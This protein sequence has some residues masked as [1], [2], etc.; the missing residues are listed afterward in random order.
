MV[1]TGLTDG[2]TATSLP[3]TAGGAGVEEALFAIAFGSNFPV[4][5]PG[6]ASTP[7]VAGDWGELTAGDKPDLRSISSKILLAPPA[8]AASRCFRSFSAACFCF[9]ASSLASLSA[10]F[11]SSVGAAVAA[12]VDGFEVYS[13]C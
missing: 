1:V 8:A 3:S 10:L 12:G 13:P 6:V 7:G 11:S 2:G 9:H 5:V 4:Y